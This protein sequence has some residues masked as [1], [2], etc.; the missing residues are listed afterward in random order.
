MSLLNRLIQIFENVITSIGL[1]LST[2][3]IFVQVINRH[4]F[5]FEIMGLGD[6][7][8]YVFVFFALLSIG[9]ATREKGNAVVDII[10]STKLLKNNPKN[11][12]IHKIVINIIS[13]I[14]VGIFLSLSYKFMSTAIKYPEYGTLVRWFNG[15]WLRITVFV[16]GILIFF[17]LLYQLIYE[18]KISNNEIKE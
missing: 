4:W 5:N 7:A 13:L 3:L 16:M 15:S 12:Y 2:I 1:W 9:I 11:Q 6:L 10:L 14:L 8:L 17:H 18:I